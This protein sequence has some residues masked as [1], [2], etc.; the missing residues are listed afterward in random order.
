MSVTV[1]KC[2]RVTSMLGSSFYRY[3]HNLKLNCS[4][5]Q[6]ANLQLL[7]CASSCHDN[8]IHLPP[9]SARRMS[10]SGRRTCHHGNQSQN[11]L[12]SNDEDVIK[13][14]IVDNTE[15]DRS[16]LTPEIAL[17]LMTP[18]CP[19]WDA[20]AQQSSDILQHHGIDDPFWAFYWPG[21]QALTRYIL[22]YPSVVSGKDVLDVGSGCGASAI[23]AS[24][25]G[26]RSVLANDID[27]VSIQ[28]IKLNA[29]L[30]DVT[31][32]TTSRNLVGQSNNQWDVVLLGD[33]FYDKDFTDTVTDWL[34]HL[35]DVGTT[36]LI[37][38]PGRIF[39]Q[40][41]PVKRRLVNIFKVD[42]SEKCRQE[43][44]GMTQGFVWKL[45]ES[46]R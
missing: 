30:N 11:G 40:D 25:S 43:N 36:V 4:A 16:H 41:H 46:E 2:L 21:G 12:V 7:N 10:S 1:R 23:A 38:D 42:L 18:A 24:M 6:R 27:R 9:L 34:K 33:M 14:F 37:G 45:C 44:N 28:T 26:A 19:L 13:R 39:L 5:I 3:H 17:R 32:A 8:H 15:V 29:E 31:V 20:P 35:A 22:D